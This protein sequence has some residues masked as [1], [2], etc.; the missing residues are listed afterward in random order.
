[1]FLKNEDADA[2]FLY[3]SRAA[4]PVLFRHSMPKSCIRW[5]ADPVHPINSMD[6]YSAAARL[7]LPKGGKIMDEM[8]SPE[9][10]QYLETI[11][12]LIEAKAKTPREAAEIVRN[13]KI[14]A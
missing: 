13:M 6:R 10:N 5:H 12:E 9:L 4:T 14:K 3:Y 7:H 8:T 11:A 2:F 1:M